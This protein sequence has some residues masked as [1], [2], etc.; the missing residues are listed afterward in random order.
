[1]MIAVLCSAALPTMAMMITPTKVWVNPKVTIAGSSA[2]TRN[3]AMT[4]TPTVA[5]PRMMPAFFVDQWGSSSS[6]ASVS[7][8]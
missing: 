2:C 3:S 5:R 1:M 7:P 8:A 6:P 4:T